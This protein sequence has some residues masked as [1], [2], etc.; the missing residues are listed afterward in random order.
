MKQ[1]ILL[2]LSILSVCSSYAQNLSKYP[3]GN[4]GCSVY[5]F[6][7]PGTF[8]LDK[9][10]DTSDIYTA[11]CVVEDLTYGIICVK[12]KNKIADLDLGEA[13]L[14]SYLDFLKTTY[15][16]KSASGYGKGHHLKDRQ[17]TRGVID[18]WKDANDAN[19]KVKGWTDGKF[20]IVLYVVSMSDIPETKANVFLD[21]LVLP[22]L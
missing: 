8:N 2:L 4:S 7:D 21:G 6:C 9:T 17:D 13:T 14:L 18:Y 11:Q 10:P 12:L 20:M 19:W 3:I 5:L 22:G 1:L 15:K 16:I